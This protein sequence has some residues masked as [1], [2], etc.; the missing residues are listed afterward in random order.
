MS[1]G[2]WKKRR[3]PQASTASWE[4]MSHFIGYF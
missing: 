1:W 2:T 3:E 4:E